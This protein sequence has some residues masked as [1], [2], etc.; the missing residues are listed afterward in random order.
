LYKAGNAVKGRIERYVTFLDNLSTHYGMRAVR[1]RV[2]TGMRD[3]DE[4]LTRART[5]LESRISGAQAYLAGQVG[6][7]EALSPVATLERGYSIVSLRE[8]GEIVKASGQVAPGDRLR[9]R[10]SRGSAEAC[11]EKT[12]EEK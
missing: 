3:L 8:S 6:K 12:E 11:V 7:A 2:I 5:T 9:I 10:F 4:A 1:D